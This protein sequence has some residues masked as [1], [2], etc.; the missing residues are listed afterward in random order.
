MTHELIFFAIEDGTGWEQML[1]IY[2]YDELGVWQLED[3]QRR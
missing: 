1:Q 3:S 2:Q